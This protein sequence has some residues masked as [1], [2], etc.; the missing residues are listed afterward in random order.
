MIKTNY[1][2]NMRITKFIAISD[3][4]IRTYIL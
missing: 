2:A 3:V 1:S 4:K